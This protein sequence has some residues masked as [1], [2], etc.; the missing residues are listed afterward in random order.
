MGS[1]RTS[2]SRPY[3]SSLKHLFEYIEELNRPLQSE[4]SLDHL[5][6]Y[7][8]KLSNSLSNTLSNLVRASAGCDEKSLEYV[9]A[10]IDEATE[11]ITTARGLMLELHRLRILSASNK[12]SMLGLDQGVSG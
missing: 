10:A 2:S 3:S 7:T 1:L 8:H 9:S 4:P 5:L 11:S 6:T 12:G